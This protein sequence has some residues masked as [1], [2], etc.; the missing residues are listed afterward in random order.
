MGTMGP[1]G[2]F[3]SNL[4]AVSNMKIEDIKKKALPVLKRHHASKAGI[5]GSAAQ[6]RMRKGSDVDILVEIKKRISLL[7]I[8]GIEQELE[9]AIGKK[10]DLVEYSAINPML[11]KR[12]LGEE[13]RIL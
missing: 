1:E 3:L 4:L 10:V 2:S 8:I 13:V 9:A 5:F 11:R 12:I 6:G 7:D